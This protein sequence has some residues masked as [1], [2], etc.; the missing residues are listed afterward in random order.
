MNIFIFYLL[1]ISYKLSFFVEA[2][3]RYGTRMGDIPIVSCGERA[4]LVSFEYLLILE[5]SKLTN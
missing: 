3:W 4:M 2:L 1:P 5:L